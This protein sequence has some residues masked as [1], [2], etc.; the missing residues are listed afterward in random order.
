MKKAPRDI[1]SKNGII[2]KNSNISYNTYFNS[3]GSIEIHIQNSK[4]K[5][6]VL[7]YDHK[8][9]AEQENWQI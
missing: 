6:T 5:N 8:F 9:E 3:D 2:K 4:N 1:Y 7:Y